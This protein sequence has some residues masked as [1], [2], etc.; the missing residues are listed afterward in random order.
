MSGL[1]AIEQLKASGTEAPHIEPNTQAKLAILALVDAAAD[2]LLPAD[3]P[4]TL[5]SKICRQL[6][7]QTGFRPPGGWANVASIATAAGF[8]TVSPDGFRAN[9]TRDELEKL[10]PHEIR[11]KCLRGFTEWLAPP[12][13]AAGLFVCLGLH[14]MWGLRVV[15]DLK[16][17]FCNGLTKEHEQ[18]FPKV[19]L[20]LIRK[21]IFGAISCVFASL[22]ELDATQ[23]YPVDALVPVIVEACRCAR[24]VVGDSQ[25]PGSM[26]V[27]VADANDSEAAFRRVADVAIIDLLDT[28]LVPAG[29]AIRTTDGGFMIEREAFNRLTIGGFTQQQQDAWYGWMIS[30]EPRFHVA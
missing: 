26:P 22:R 13:V 6:E 21:T 17:P 7:R 28:V 9:V 23:S 29:A 2:M 24:E 5:S 4:W 20:E 11:L 10:D 14:P 1:Q 15:Q 18:M 30:P 25:P 19:Q 12:A 27:Y 8:L 3:S 16:S